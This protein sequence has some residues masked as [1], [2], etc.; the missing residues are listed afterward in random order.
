MEQT[1]EQRFQL[2]KDEVRAAYASIHAKL[3]QGEAE[4]LA[5]LDASK[6]FHLSKVQAATE[7]AKQPE[8][9]LSEIIFRQCSMGNTE[10]RPIFDYH[11]A[12]SEENVNDCLETEFDSVF[13]ELEMKANPGTLKHELEELKGKLLESQRLLAEAVERENKLEGKYQKLLTSYKQKED[14]YQIELDKRNKSNALQERQLKASNQPPINLDRSSSFHQAPE[15][16]LFPPLPN[17]P[18]PSKYSSNLPPMPGRQRQ[19]SVVPVQPRAAWE[20]PDPVESSS[21]AD[22][23]NPRS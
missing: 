3:A 18:K 10:V 9:P 8:D 2:C 12:V 21:N 1:C 7:I 15:A 17:I 4:L 23:R 13:P 6:A 14:Y 20:A 22:R 16:A 5:A 19:N 11:V